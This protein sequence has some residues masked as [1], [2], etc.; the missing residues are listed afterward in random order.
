MNIGQIVEKL[1]TGTK[2]D[3]L[4]SVL[5]FSRDTIKQDLKKV[6][7][8]YDNKKKQ[9]VFTGYESEYKNTLQIPYSD[10]R[11]QGRKQRPSKDK[12]A[13]SASS[14]SSQKEVRK[15][16]ESSNTPSATL[17]DSEIKKL[18]DL[19]KSIDSNE[20][21]LE[22]AQLPSAEEKKKHSIEISL[23]TFN[24]FNEFSERYSG[25]RIS[26][27]DLIEIALNRLMKDFS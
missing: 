18:K 5:G 21:Y 11:K 1:N 23:D 22:L 25:K 14:E 24:A 16:S 4:V 2:Y 15:T 17:S 19:L 7:F 13:L 9:M 10:L 20:L 8:Q 26:K 3:E 12:K 27:N 6:G